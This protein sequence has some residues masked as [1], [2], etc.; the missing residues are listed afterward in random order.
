MSFS[1]PRKK[2]GIYQIKNIVNDKLYIGSAVCYN[3][4]WNLHNSKP[5]TFN[6]ETH[7]IKEWSDII[8][9]NYDTLYKRLTRGW[10]IYDTFSTPV[11]NK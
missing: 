3:K 10:S 5:I 6:G 11:G 2:S 7:S 9:I 1:G 8:G 4:R